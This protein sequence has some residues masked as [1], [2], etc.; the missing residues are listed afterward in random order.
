MRITEVLGIDD[1]APETNW[2]TVKDPDN[3]GTSIARWRD[4]QGQE[5]RMQFNPPN[6]PTGRGAWTNNSKIDFSRVNPSTGALGFDIT[7]QGSASKVL[8]GV[9]Q[10]MRSYLDQRPNVDNLSFTSLEPSRTRAYSRIIDRLAPQAGLVGTRQDFPDR[11]EFTLTRAQK[12][13]KH[14]PLVQP[15]PRAEPKPQP[16]GGSSSK[17]VPTM[18]FAPAG[19]GGRNMHDMNPFKIP[20]SEAQA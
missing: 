1:P 4:P 12:D 6:D 9:A 8:S 20:F 14:E 7:G 2:H 16:P 3:N 5:I 11:T 15:K 18:P 13:Q 10:N 17:A 19:G